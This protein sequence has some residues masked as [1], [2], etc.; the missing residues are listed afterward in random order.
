MKQDRKK[1]VIFAVGFAIFLF[2]MG[3]I[4]WFTIGSTERERILSNKIIVSDDG[5]LQVS[6]DFP[7]GFYPHESSADRNLSE[8]GS[9]YWK[10]P[11]KR[12]FDR[13]EALTK[14]CAITL[15]IYTPSGENLF[16]DIN[17][18]I[19]EF[20]DA[21]GDSHVFMLV[22]GNASITC[23]LR[24]DLG[25]EEHWLYLQ[26]GDVIYQLSAHMNVQ[27]WQDF[28]YCLYEKG[29]LQIEGQTVWERE[30]LLNAKDG[31]EGQYFC[32]RDLFYTFTCS[33]ADGVSAGTELADYAH[34]DDGIYLLRRHFNT[35][36]TGYDYLEEFTLRAVKPEPAFDT[37]EEMYAYYLEKHPDMTFYEVRTSKEKQEED[38]LPKEDSFF[39]FLREEK[40]ES[41]YFEWNDGFYQVTSRG[42]EN[43][44]SLVDDTRWRLKY[45]YNEIYS[46]EEYE[47]GSSRKNFQ[48]SQF[49]FEQDMG[50]GRIFVFHMEP[51]LA[52]ESTEDSQRTRFLVEVSEKDAEKPFQVFYVLSEEYNPFSFEDFNADGYMDLSVC[53]YNGARGSF[54][55]FY[56]WRPSV[57]QFVEGPEELEYFWG[58]SVDSDTRRLYVE[59]Y[60]D[61]YSGACDTYQWS[62]E[63][64]C[65]I[66]RSIY[67]DIYPWDDEGKAKILVKEY[68]QDR[69]HIIIDYEY[70]RDKYEELEE[71]IWD[72]Y[73][74]DFVWERQIKDPDTGELYTIR[75]TQPPKRDGEGEKNSGLWDAVLY[76]YG[77]DTDLQR[78]ISYETA[79]PY[80][81][82]VWEEQESVLK[83]LYEDGSETIYTLEQIRGET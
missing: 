55:S 18:Q 49:D 9:F 51:D 57:E 21:D 2:L 14:R 32:Y 45:N 4:L 8:I 7:W 5:R 6:S 12:I 73:Y 54:A 17:R 16:E 38:S 44:L 27:T 67:Y 40:S 19:H 30:S 29:K 78:R 25:E 83:V 82:I 81:E 71:L 60:Y 41:A 1:I 64:D 74:N 39:R 28:L 53:Y 24:L 80:T 52:H 56:L 65:E 20:R 66:I 76:I 10:T 23:L 58:Y 77:K 36:E 59:Y 79:A 34:D 3:G 75:Y 47:G 62:K 26:Q 68:L 46:W 43:T 72:S 63:T 42:A 13:W 61:S 22:D 70:D 50:D 33:V 35:A 31:E 48:T 15:S 11:G 37:Q 69:E